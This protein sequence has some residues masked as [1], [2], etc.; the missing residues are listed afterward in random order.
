MPCQ[1]QQLAA[2]FRAEL[3]RVVRVHARGREQPLRPLLCETDGL[4]RARER[5]TGD[6]QLWDTRRARARDHLIAVI[7]VTLMREV[8]PDVDEGSARRSG[9]AMFWHARETFY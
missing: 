5:R 3:R 6:D 9:C 4:A 8:Y 2:A 7:L 1:L